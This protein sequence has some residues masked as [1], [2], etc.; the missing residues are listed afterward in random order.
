MI[1]LS[2]SNKFIFVNESHS[3]NF[4]ASSFHL[5]Y[6]SLVFQA[7]EVDANIKD[8]TA[9]SSTTAHN[10][11]TAIGDS[12]GV[13]ILTY[14]YNSRK[15]ALGGYLKFVTSRLAVM[16][17]MRDILRELLVIRPS[18]A[19]D[20]NFLMVKGVVDSFGDIYISILFER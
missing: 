8:C 12:V 14:I 16:I 18:L 11:H 20:E 2:V 5:L 3:L 6:I 17:D 13:T 1:F 19:T 7:T 15:Y 9:N 10:G 4:F